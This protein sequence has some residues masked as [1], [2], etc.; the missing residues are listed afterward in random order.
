MKSLREI[1]HNLT[2]QGVGAN[3]NETLLLW[4][5]LKMQALSA[6]RV[7][8]PYCFAAVVTLF[9]PSRTAFAE[10]STSTATATAETLTSSVSLPSI[11]PGT[12]GIR[13]DETISIFGRRMDST[14]VAG[15]AH[16]IPTEELERFQYDD[17]GRILSKV[18][19]VY[20]RDEDGF[21]LRPNIG[22]RGA[23][24]D[25]SAKV[26]LLEDGVLLGPA[27]YAA[28]A[29]YYFPLTTRMVGVEV[30]KGPAAVRHGPNTIGGAVNLNTA[31]PPSGTQGLLDLATGQFGYL[32]SHGRLGYGNDYLGVVLEGVHLQSTGFKELGDDA[33]TGFDKN[34]VMAKLRFN[35]DPAADL[36]H[37]L[38]MKF[39]F[40]NEGSNE[41]YLGITDDDFEEAPLQR[42][43]GSAR[44][45]ME[46]HRTQ[47]HATYSV[48]AG[49]STE[50]SLTFYRH[51]FDRTW[52][53]LASFRDGTSLYQVVQAPQGANAVYLAVLRG[54][55]DSEPNQNLVVTTNARTFLSEGIQLSANLAGDFGF[56]RHSLALGAR[57]HRDRV[58]R[59]HTEQ[60]FLMRSGALVQDGEAPERAR[61][62]EGSARAIALYAQEEVT[63]FDRLTL[64]PGLR[65]EWIRT[66]LE[67]PL[68]TGD[69][70]IAQSATDVV[71]VP[72]IGAL[73]S[74]YGGLS[75]LG[76]VHR[77][78]SPVSPGQPEQTDPETSI[79]YEGGFRYRQGVSTA[80]VVGFLNDY[81]N[82]TGECTFSVGCPEDLLTQQFNA[83]DVR[84][85]GL[86][87]TLGHTVMLWRSIALELKAAYTWTRSRFG[88]SFESSNPLWGSVTEGD[89][90]PYLP[91]HLLNVMVG[92][93]RPGYGLF[94]SYTYTSPMRDVAGQ[95][96]IAPNESTDPQ[97]VVD[98]TA[99]YEVL[100][101]A[102]L[103]F[104]VDNLLN[105]KYIAS[106]R[107]FGPRPGKPLQMQG[108]L[109]Y[110]FGVH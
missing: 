75:V 15:S 40:A 86:E 95:R 87:A 71:V 30:F 93:S 91:E 51:E 49:D 76:G 48:S 16:S 8:Y 96:D 97:H 107:P 104:R 27:P 4:P 83:G 3:K 102:E 99:R 92:V 77:G 100:K 55:T 61:W 105:Q 2:N 82:L 88:S 25:R 39:G 1:V 47:I 45:R 57:F 65:F 110:R 62:D 84:V 33:D 94:A 106:R 103:Y 21:G 28:P 6:V 50:V 24:S 38:E 5:N 98:I 63:L 7:V 72:G 53:R 81:T 37:R 90:L 80:E 70:P 109:T 74:I 58:R 32:K 36:F 12:A 43:L 56:L 22:L 85:L 46:W 79:N 34:E 19:G 31:S 35:S 54:E 59:T 41:T 101:G 108:G 69:A 26:T 89:E 23:S 68:A 42:Y 73:W 29:A 64:T 20:L 14:R 17:V 67:N 9:L 52:E 13:I 10:T 44:G 60:G 78:F 18:P 66:R 11:G